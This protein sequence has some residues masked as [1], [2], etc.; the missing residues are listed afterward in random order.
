MSKKVK[1]TSATVTTIP[2][3]WEET[4][5]VCRKCSKRLSG[6]FGKDGEVT[7]KSALRSHL[8]KTGRRRSTA[9]IDVVCFGICPKKAVVIVRSST[10]DRLLVVGAGTDVASF[11]D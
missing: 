3:A 7:L 8:R 4:L 5:L 11:L 10:P 6:G 9:I 1:A 2:T